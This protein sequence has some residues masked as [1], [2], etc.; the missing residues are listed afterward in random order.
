[1]PI[2]L[3]KKYRL[4]LR[5]YSPLIRNKNQLLVKKIPQENSSFLLRTMT[6][7][8]S[9]LLLSI[10]GNYINRQYLKKNKRTS[11]I[12]LRKYIWNSNLNKLN[13][14]NDLEKIIGF[15]YKYFWFFHDFETMR[16]NYF[17][18]LKVLNLYRNPYDSVVSNYFFFIKNR[19][20]K[21]SMECYIKQFMPDY[22]NRL[23]ILEYF[24]NKENIIN[25][26]YEELE[27]NTEKT[28]IKILFFLNLKV[29]IKQIRLAIKDSSI[30][31]FLKE[32]KNSGKRNLISNKTKISFIRNINK[33]GYKK[34]LSK[35][36][37]YLIQNYLLKNDINLSK[38]KKNIKFF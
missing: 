14:R 20:I 3:I 18:C 23:K 30:K 9:H 6:K 26:S 24:K 35:E 1:M 27:A 31:N 36:Q 32:E 2:Q 21:T 4:L 38:L 34:Y 28:I 33:E 10:I 15:K 25:I 11:I 22:I 19:N 12:N 17:K 16:Y 5:F 29:N 13:E 8:G 7:S 37:I